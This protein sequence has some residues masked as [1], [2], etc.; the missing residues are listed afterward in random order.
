MSREQISRSRAVLTSV[1]IFL[2]FAIFTAWLPS[3]LIRSPFLGNATQNVADGITL[4]VWGGFFG[5][6][7]IALRWA[8]KREL[9]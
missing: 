4:V 2:Y 3:W 5:A 1:A 8:Q 6:G 7:V 9:I